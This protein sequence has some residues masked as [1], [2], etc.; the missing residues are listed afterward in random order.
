MQQAKS[1]LKDNPAGYRLLGDFY[2]SQ[3]ELEKAT[4]EFSALYSQHPKDKAIAETYVQ[5]L[6]QQNR[7]DDAAKVNDATLQNFPSDPAAMILEGAILNRQQKQSDAVQ[8]LEQAVKSAPDNAVGHFQLGLAY[9]GTKNFGQAEAQWREAV[10]LQPTMIDAHRALATL[11]L[12]KHD[13]KLLAESGAALKSIEPGAVDGYIYEAQAEFWQGN[14]ANAEADLKKAIEMAPQNP[15]GYVQMGNLRLG[16]KKS[17]EAEK[18]FAQALKLDPSSSDALTGLVNIAVE[19]KD[20]AKA[21]R[22]VQDQVALV[23]SSS[24]FYFL[25]GQIELRNQDQAKAEAALEKSVDL[26][27]SNAAAVLLLGSIQVARGSVDRAIATYQN[28]IK[29]NPGDP[30]LYAGLGGAYEAHQDWQQAQDAYKKALEIQ[31]D[32]SLAAN[33]LAYVMLEHGGN[34]NIALSLA[35]TARKGLP[36]EAFSADT[37]GW[38]YYKQGVY[39]AAIETLQEAVTANPINPTYHYHLGLAYQKSK[40]VP[41]AKKE[42]AAALKLNP[43]PDQAEEI[44]K[45]LGT[46]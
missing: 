37:L 19:R 30:R 46:L 25:L 24:N 20:A 6:L 11:A 38:A 40:N 21:L 8:V 41:M 12:P 4:D 18:Y 33:N 7:L 22:L 42:F 13:A 26:D 17:D 14:Q 5:I 45:N 43:K 29:N 23:P 36:N 32:Y 35:Q 16:Q 2:L 9:A 39:N 27:K 3:R 28:A 1:A 31:P 34:V 15:A 44:K 10:R